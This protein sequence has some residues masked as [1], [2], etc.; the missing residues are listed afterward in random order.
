MN[1]S[2]SGTAHCNYRIRV[3]TAA[4]LSGLFA[5]ASLPASAQDVCSQLDQ[6]VEAGEKDNFSSLKH[7]ALP[8]A[9]CE[10]NG[11]FECSWAHRYMD[12]NVVNQ[13][14]R[15]HRRCDRRVETVE[16]REEEYHEVFMKYDY[17]HPRVVRADRRQREAIARAEQVC[18]PYKQLRDSVYESALS[19][20]EALAASI[21]KCLAT[22]NI[23][24]SWTS[25]TWDDVAG[26]SPRSVWDTHR[27]DGQVKL[28]LRV[29]ADRDDVGGIQFYLR[30]SRK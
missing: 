5:L 4:F 9:A 23:R 24:G 17:D 29:D 20:A 7:F 30:F 1:H 13:L 3:I 26:S 27:T 6:I 19:D 12:S 10:S 8:Q 21:K 2:R 14:R 22:G 28:R 18:G 25:L 11:N 15:G 16:K